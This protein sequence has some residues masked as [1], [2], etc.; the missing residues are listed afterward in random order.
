MEIVETFC[1]TPPTLKVEKEDLPLLQKCEEIIKGT[2]FKAIMVVLF[3]GSECRRGA[4]PATD[5]QV[6]YYSEKEEDD[7]VYEFSTPADEVRELFCEVFSVLLSTGRYK[8][9]ITGTQVVDI[10]YYAPCYSNPM[11]AFE[12]EVVHPEVHTVKL[13]KEATVEAEVFVEDTDGGLV[14]YESS[15]AGNL[16]TITIDFKEVRRGIIKEFIQKLNEGEEDD[17]QRNAE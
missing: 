14:P 12:V 2:N 17:N 11:G 3:P 10:T 9:G 7:E 8:L 4:K 13:T 6:V 15:T 5:E 1:G 16:I